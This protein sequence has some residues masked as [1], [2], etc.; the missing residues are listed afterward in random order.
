MS[1]VLTIVQGDTLE[2]SLSIDGADAGS[3]EKIIF[4]SKE[5]N[6]VQVFTEYAPGEYYLRIEGNVTKYFKPKVTDYDLT[7][8]FV[9]GER[10]TGSYH[11]KLIVLRKFN[12]VE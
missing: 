12:K 9:D 6:I 10:V 1:D 5:Q 2:I 4:S 7:V 11:N 3:V 8:I